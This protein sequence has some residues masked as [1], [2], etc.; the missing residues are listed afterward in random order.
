M[1]SRLQI[2]ALR[3]LF[4]ASVTVTCTTCGRELKPGKKPLRYEVLAA[5]GCPGCGGRKYTY[6]FISEAAKNRAMAALGQGQGS[7]HVR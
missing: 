4:N 7:A 1:A 2:Q 3:L 6:D 5:R